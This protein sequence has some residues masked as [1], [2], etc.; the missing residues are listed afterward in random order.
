MRVIAALV[1]IEYQIPFETIWVKMVATNNTRDDT[2]FF[3][4]PLLWSQREQIEPS[5]CYGSG[6]L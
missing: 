4:F 2:K 6:I 5:F 1:V 3:E